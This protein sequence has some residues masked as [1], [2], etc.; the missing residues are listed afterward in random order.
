MHIYLE[1]VVCNNAN[2]HNVK[3]SQKITHYRS[4]RSSIYLQYIH[5]F[6]YG[7]AGRV[8][9]NYHYTALNVKYSNAINAIRRL[10]YAA[11]WEP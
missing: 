4:C 10:N 8:A 5:A 1:E 7:K 6:I 2:Q 9:I 11:G 3:I